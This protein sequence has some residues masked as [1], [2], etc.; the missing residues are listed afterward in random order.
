MNHLKKPFYSLNKIKIVKQLKWYLKYKL[1][2]FFI[3]EPYYGICSIFKN[4]I[5]ITSDKREQKLIVRLT[6]I[7]DRINRVFLTIE[8]LLQQ[9]LKPDQIILWL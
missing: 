2:N 6:S 3:I 8:S 5:G 1:F 7:P 9:S 4:K